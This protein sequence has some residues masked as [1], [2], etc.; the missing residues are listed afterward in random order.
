V[1][2]PVTGWPRLLRN[3]SIEGPLHFQ[4]Q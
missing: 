2:Q 1:R 4:V 3:E